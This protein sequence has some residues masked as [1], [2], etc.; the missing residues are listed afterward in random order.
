MSV[1]ASKF[2]ANETDIDAIPILLPSN[3]GS[4]AAFTGLKNRL[5]SIIFTTL[6]T[7]TPKKDTT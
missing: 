2:E 3:T 1:V 6:A 5:P 4:H 7:A